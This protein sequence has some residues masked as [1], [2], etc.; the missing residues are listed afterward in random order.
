MKA[1]YRE[2]S[3]LEDTGDVATVTTVDT[4]GEDISISIVPLTNGV[5]ATAILTLDDAD[6]AHLIELLQTARNGAAKS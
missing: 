1:I 2:D 6:T 3:Q 5:E 4:V